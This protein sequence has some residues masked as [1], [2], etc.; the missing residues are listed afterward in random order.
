MSKPR[1]WNFICHYAK[2]RDN[3]CSIIGIAKKEGMIV[4]QSEL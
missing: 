4:T 3:D 2:I 1:P